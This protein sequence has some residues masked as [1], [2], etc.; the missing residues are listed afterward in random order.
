MKKT[1]TIRVKDIN[2]SV[3]V[4][5]FLVV[6]SF[7]FYVFAQDYSDSDKN[8]FLDS[9][10]DGLTDLEE[11]SYGTDPGNRDTDSDGYSDGSEVK[12]GYD[13]LV[14]APGDRL[15]EETSQ[16]EISPEVAGETDENNL[17][18]KIAQKI[19]E[20][21]QN[22]DAE[23]QELSMEEIKSLVS[24]SLNS[25]FSEADLPEIEKDSILIKKQNY[26]SL[27]DEKAEEKRKEDFTNYITAIF[28]IF[29]SNS[30]RPI[31]SASDIISISSEMATEI[32]SAMTSRDSKAIAELQQSSENILEQI[33]EVEVPE[34]LLEIHT[35]ALSFALYGKS[36]G[37]DALS[38][39]GD[40]PLRDIAV[41]SRVEGLIGSL[42]E[43][44][45]EVQEEFEK[46]GLSYDET[47]KGKLEDLGIDMSDDEELLKKLSEE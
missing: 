8:V 25:D 34:E 14:P 15:S 7:S 41:F 13:P 28:Y 12:A 36:L 3:F 20:I 26:D 37:D 19:S 16:V 27:S 24:E 1:K 43:F 10:Q 47:L 40:D 22:P 18:E 11:R 31:T 46:Y 42:L 9:D 6:S 35:K 4:L 5:L 29:S 2:L 38:S 30:P 23:E 44:S 21:S 17:T 39:K 32:T 33:K 45:E